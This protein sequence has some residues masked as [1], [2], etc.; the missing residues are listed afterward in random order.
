[1]LDK[2]RNNYL[3]KEEFIM[4]LMTFYCS[5]FDDKIK[6]IF[7]IYDFNRDGYISQQDIIPIIS[8]MPVASSI[9]VRGEGMYTQ[10]GGGVQSFQERV[11]TL[12]EMLMV[13]R[14]CFGSRLL[15]NLKEFT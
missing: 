3:N 2:D 10:E 6:F 8:C 5:S 13:L 9:N 12:E 4:G 15:I 1:M 14:H 11:D 7:D